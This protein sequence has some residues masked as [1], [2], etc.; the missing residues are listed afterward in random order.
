MPGQI[1]IAIVDDHPVV[2]AGLH[3]L[4]DR[5]DS[6]LIVAEGECADDALKIARA[7][8]PE[9]LLL[10]VGMPGNGIIAARELRRH[11]PEIKIV[12]LTVSE[13]EDHLSAALECGASGYILKGIVAEDLIRSLHQVY[14]GEIC[15]SPSLAV[16]VLRHRAVNPRSASK[17]ANKLRELTEQEQEVARLVAEGLTNKEIANRLQVG[18]RAVKGRLTRIMRKLSV[19]NR[20]AVAL[21]KYAAGDGSQD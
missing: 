20:T 18:E 1:R 7:N 11:F 15:I 3:Q 16:Q 6:F 17:F 10:D 8:E 2:R 19:H 14:A 13:N 12:M 21:A 9:I 4:I 5:N